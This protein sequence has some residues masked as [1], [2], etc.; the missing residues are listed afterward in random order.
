MPLTQCTILP[1]KVD[2]WKA[3]TGDETQT[4]L[5]CDEIIANK[6]GYFF[7]KTNFGIFRVANQCFGFPRTVPLDVVQ[8]IIIEFKKNSIFDAPIDFSVPGNFEI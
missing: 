1:A 5:E 4:F 3:L 2:R 8:L 6:A 7:G